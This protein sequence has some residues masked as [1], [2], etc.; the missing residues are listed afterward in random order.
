M[1]GLISRLLGGKPDPNRQVGPGQ[2]P[3]VGVGGYVLGTG[4]TGQY[5]FPGST[6]QTR[7]FPS[8]GRV[9][10]SPRAVKIRGDYDTDANSSSGTDPETR[11]ASYRGDVPGARTSNP[12]LTRPV[13]APQTTIRQE[14][15]SNSPAEFYGGPALRTTPGRNDT[16]GGYIN[17]TGARAMGL[18]AADARD[19]TTPWVEAQPVISGG[20]PGA[21]NVRNQ[22]AQRYK[23]PAGQIHTYLSAPRADQATVNPGGQATDGNVHPGAVVQPVS[24]PNRALFEEI[25][26]S[27][28]REMP[29]GGR[30]DGAR[31]ADLNGQRYYAT[32]QTDQFMNGGQGE[33]G[34]Q[35]LNGSGNKRPVGFTQPAP[36]TS[37][38]YDTTN[39]VGTV[40]NPNTAPDQQPS[41]IY[42]SP[43]GLRASNG[44]G[45][46]G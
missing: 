37:N 35:R 31:G 41:S 15:Q 30:G 5:G 21:Q 33:F 42:V 9:P 36:W 4:P 24:V 1:A 18:S 20:V 13:T 34:I 22:V 10:Y 16:A 43:G 12:R 40:D 7:T 25:T 39:S 19:T 26:W 46:T 8:N 3:A 2:E 6:S 44:T 27:I 29:Y 28:L 17:R 45:R 11:Q 38:F 14:M 23:N 32:G